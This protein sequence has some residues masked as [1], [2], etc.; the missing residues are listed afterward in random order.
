LI[1]GPF[2]VSFGL[3][4]SGH[5]VIICGG[6]GLLP[7][8]DLLDYFLKYTVYEALRNTSGEEVAQFAN[9]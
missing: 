2:G 3:P 6:T 1:Q 5:F 7:F 9:L 4:E 8:L